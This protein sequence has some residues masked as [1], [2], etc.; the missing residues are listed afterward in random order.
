MSTRN[1]PGATAESPVEQRT[2]RETGRVSDRVYTRQ[3][4]QHTQPK[5]DA[6]GIRQGQPHRGAPKGYDAERAQRPWLGKGQQ[7]AQ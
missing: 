3:P 5:T 6:R 7:Q 1:S 4:P 2:V